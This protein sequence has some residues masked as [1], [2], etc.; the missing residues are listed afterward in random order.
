MRKRNTIIYMVII[1]I[2]ILTTI[3][4][5]IYRKYPKYSKDKEYV[6]EYVIGEEGIKGSV[7]V[8]KYAN[9]PAY[10]IGADKEGYAVF[11]NPDK[12]FAQMKIDFAKGL[13]AIK[14]EYKLSKLSRWNFRTYGQYGWQLTKTKDAEII[15]QGARISQ[16]FDIYE[17]SFD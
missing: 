15:N 13:A 6:R 2:A 12:A 16:F 3:S 8:T 10:E 7:D 11:K 14:E 1:F 4:T 5:F 17:N 9:N